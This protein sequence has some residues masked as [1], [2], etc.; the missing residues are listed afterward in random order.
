MKD[1]TKSDRSTAD[2]PNLY[3]TKFP[4]SRLT[5]NISPNL[6][7][8]V[9]HY[10]L[11]VDRVSFSVSYQYF[12]EVRSA[13]KR[14]FTYEGYSREKGKSIWRYLCGDSLIQLVRYR[15]SYWFSVTVHDVTST[16][17]REV[18]SALFSTVSW[19]YGSDPVK[20]SQ[21]E[22]A[23]DFYPVKGASAYDVGREILSALSMTHS[24]TDAFRVFE[25]TVYIGTRGNVRSG[26]KGVRCYPK[27]ETGAYRVE[28]QL[29]RA[30]LKEFHLPSD[31][32]P[33]AID[34]W[35]YL[36]FRRPMD[37]SVFERLF[38]AV[39]KKM[40]VDPADSSTMRANLVRNV[41]MSD[42]KCYFCERS[43]RCLYAETKPFSQPAQCQIDAFKVIK[44]RH[45]LNYGIGHFFPK[46]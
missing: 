24:R 6:N 41:R 10:Q 36:E 2:Q 8:L 13:L 19:R 7:F 3:R 29:N 18:L 42:L 43:E 4:I 1:E 11:S 20:L 35:R 46:R 38:R 30:A 23:T 21:C 15:S 32:Y 17:W 5:V 28:V 25:D 31:F 37:E 34:P 39:C 40:G 27:P 22:L 26:V 33:L 14:S 45:R 9:S 16:V 12:D 44:A